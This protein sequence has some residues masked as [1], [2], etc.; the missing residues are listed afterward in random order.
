MEDTMKNTIKY[1]GL[2]LAAAA[3]IFTGAI[4]VSADW[5]EGFSIHYEGED[6]ERYRDLNSGE[7]S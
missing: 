7:N 6:L 1:F 5:N 4:G 3:L 2:V